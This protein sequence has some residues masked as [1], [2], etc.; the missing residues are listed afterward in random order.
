M[1]LKSKLAKLEKQLN[2]GKKIYLFYLYDNGVLTE[3]NESEFTEAE[4][5]TADKIVIRRNAV[6]VGEKR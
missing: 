5:K 3:T 6:K 2:K 1:N 4:R